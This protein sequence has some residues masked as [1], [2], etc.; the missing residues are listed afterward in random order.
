MS[1]TGQIRPT[2]NARAE[3][4]LSEATA[5]EQQ[6]SVAAELFAGRLRFDLLTTPDGDSWRLSPGEKA[7]LARL[8]DFC[9]QQVDP[10]VIEC[11]D[12]VP[13][14]VIEGLKNLGGFGMRIPRR[15]GG[16]GLSVVCY[17]RALMIVGSTHSAL[18]ELLAAHQAI[19]L[20]QPILLFGTDQQRR[21]Y[22]PR[23]AREIS[24]FAL[25][26][27]DIGNDPYRIRA[28]ATP[29]PASGNYT[30]DGVK[31]WTTN[32]VIA[33]LIVVVA[34]VPASGGG[35]GGM[36]A[37][38][39]EAD[40]PGVI[41]EHRGCFLG[42][43][44]LENG[45]IRLDRVVV[46][47]GSRIGAEGQGLEIALAAQDV[48]RLS[49]P[50]VS[51]AAARWCLKIAREWAGVREQWGRPIGEHDA[52]AGKLAFIAAT[53]FAL[54]ALVEVTAHRQARG[55]ADT[56]LDAELAKLF[57]SETAWLVA[58][59]LLQVR[60][61]RGYETAA[62]AVARGERGVPVEQVLRDLRIGRIFDGSSEA[63]RG[64]IAHTVL[65][66]RCTSTTEA[67][68]PLATDGTAIRGPLRD[69]LAFVAKAA[70]RLDAELDHVAAWPAAQREIRQRHL[71][72]LVDIGAE[73][74]A[75]TAACAYAQRLTEGDAAVQLADAF[76]AQA[77]TRVER[78]FTAL[79]ANT[80]D[81]DR[82]IARHVLDG[83]FT[84]LER[85]VLDP[86]TDGPWIAEP[87][88]TGRS[89]RRRFPASPPA[90]Q[91]SSR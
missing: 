12:R 50:A 73:L 56:G 22:L 14:H 37:F 40:A 7:F 84:W 62:S 41:V 55:H 90:E 82:A 11:D 72:R 54:D 9:R 5:R 15:Y 48:S 21:T 70:R 63:L 58:D 32:G 46:G 42:L 10:A 69:R 1:T 17:L 88:R 87:T 47:A 91:R 57:A 8:T 19:G 43:R 2:D 53:A 67:S 38:V 85:G 6:P 31:L 34:D 64:F 59:E 33:S 80:D 49:L 27:P 86:S 20:T 30:L 3:P 18:S 28:T 79:A 16:L 60:G 81:S 89:V 44:G 76:C 66:G 61:G 68:A 4:T 77:R 52:V 24:A 71:A 25:T 39:V 74:Y 51:A 75:M 26:E 83:H 35:P 29:D 78:L 65:A 13:D 36:T 23:C 45:V